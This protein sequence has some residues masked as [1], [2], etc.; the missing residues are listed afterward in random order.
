MGKLGPLHMA[1]GNVKLNSYL[2]KSSAFAQKDKHRVF[3]KTQQF[4]SMN[5]LRR[6]ENISAHK[7]V[8]ISIAKFTKSRCLPADEW[9]S[10]M[11][12]IHIMEYYWATKKNELLICGTTWITHENVMHDERNQTH[13]MTYYTVPCIWNVWNRKT[14]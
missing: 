1:V 8:Y 3:Q 10:P 11:W 9:I 5:I 12:F 2:E 6:I 13:K 4:H 7:L 14:P